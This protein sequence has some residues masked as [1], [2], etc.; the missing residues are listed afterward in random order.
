MTLTWATDIH[1]DCVD[2]VYEA[3]KRLCDAAADTDGLVISGDISTSLGISSHLGILDGLSKKPVYFV[4]GNHDYY[5][6]D[7]VTVR[8]RVVGICQSSR[9][10]TYLGAFRPIEVSSGVFLL[11]SDG[12]YDA[13]NGSPQDS[14]FTMNDWLKIADFKSAIRHSPVGKIIVK[15]TVVRTARAICTASARHIAASIQHVADV[16]RHV[17]IVTHVPPFLESYTD[18]KYKNLPAAHV[19][20]WYTSRILGETLASAAETYPHIQF[21][22][23]SGHTHSPFDGDVLRN[24]RAKVGKSE[25]GTPQIAGYIDI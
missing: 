15:D 16:A 25:Y 8:K 14:D 10:L 20:P 7:I 3:A 1:L 11:G 21:T 2:D 19:V 18:A 24:V 22:V 4:L 9:H 23:I 6:S 13:G 5:Y 17:I 12:W